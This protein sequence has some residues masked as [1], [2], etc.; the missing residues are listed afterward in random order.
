[1]QFRSRL[2]VLLLI[3]IGTFVYFNSLSNGFVGDDTSQILRNTP[4]HSLKNIP[5]FFL[6]STYE[7][8]G[9]ERMKGLFYR[10]AMQVGFSVLYSLFG[11]NPFAYHFFQVLLHI[12]NSILLYFFLRKLFG[13]NSFDRHSGK[14]SASRI[15][16]VS[17]KGFWTSLSTMSSRPNGQSDEVN[18]LAFFIA[19][20][21]LVHPINNEAVVYIANLQDVLFFFFGMIALLVVQRNNQKVVISRR[22]DEKSPWNLSH[23]F[24]ITGIFL[25][26]L[27]S[28]FAK[29]TG[30]IFFVSAVLYCLLFDVKKIKLVMMSTV[31]AFLMYVFFRYGI[32]EM[33]I[34]NGSVAPIFSLP[35]LQRLQNIPAIT[36]YYLRMFLFPVDIATSQFWV[37]R[38]LNFWDFYVPLLFSL[39]CGGVLI[40]GGV[41]LLN[42]HPNPLPSW[43]RGKKKLGRARILIQHIYKN[44]LLKIYL[45][46]CSWFLLGLILHW[47]FIPLDAT[48]ADRWFYVST[49]GLLG[50]L[51]VVLYKF[52]LRSK[53]K[54]K[55]NVPLLI[56]LIVC[57]SVRT[58]IRNFDWRDGLI[59]YSHDIKIAKQNFI[60]E[61]A[62]GT[63]LINAGEYQKAKKH[64]QQSIT[65]Y[66]YYANLNNMA[67]IYAS[68]KNFS[69]SK[70]YLFKAVQVS[71]NNVVYENYANFLLVYDTPE[72]SKKFI[73]E[74]L[75]IF[76]KDAILW[77]RLAKAEYVLGE[78]QAALKAAEKAYSLSSDEK[79]K[80]LYNRLKQNQ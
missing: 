70:E 22:N 10:P 62:L 2:C 31:S 57:L 35:L 51:G 17:T 71:N 32:A 46:F 42:F 55:V 30:I 76:P 64:V 45:F 58:F 37:V 5:F 26:L 77:Q 25:L 41:W 60:L 1:M 18:E 54:P 48:V 73:R 20:F 39:L 14:R 66:P 33:F 28:L 75:K 65:E 16:T 50:M 47:Q 79:T 27:F 7:N 69:K 63:E 8:G 34:A 49:A 23:A 38:S 11:E 53:L 68:E 4:I 19:V 43:E 67:I 15:A 24:K 59:L 12:A 9:A 40:L 3:F 61:N 36:W 80:E 21:F 78:K 56:L 13:Q 52:L 44:E 72:E 74:A 6:G 29:E